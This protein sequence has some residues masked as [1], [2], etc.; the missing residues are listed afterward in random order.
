M[1]GIFLL[2]FL[3]LRATTCLCIWSPILYRKI[4][5][6]VP[7]RTSESEYLCASTSSITILERTPDVFLLTRSLFRAHRSPLAELLHLRSSPPSPPSARRSLSPLAALVRPRI[8]LVI[9]FLIS[10]PWSPVRAVCSSPVSWF[11][12]TE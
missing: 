1:F 9:P 6:S 12:N 7:R 11:P 10:T 8:P 5:L 2:S 4:L 3:F